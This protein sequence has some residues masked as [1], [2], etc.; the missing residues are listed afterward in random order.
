[1]HDPPQRWRGTSAPSL[2]G[3]KTTVSRGRFFAKSWNSTRRR[4]RRTSRSANSTAVGRGSSATSTAW[5]ASWPGSGSARR[6]PIS[7]AAK[8]VAALRRVER[9]AE[10]EELTK[11]E[12]QPPSGVSYH[13]RVL[14]KGAG[15][16]RALLPA[17]RPRQK[18][19]VG[20]GD[21]WPGGLS[22]GKEKGTQA[23]LASTG[24]S[25]WSRV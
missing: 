1:M 3:R 17:D 23:C 14:A 10:P 25:G 11:L 13:V 12:E 6:P 5:S 19:A 21:P 7:P 8:P 16:D 15:V 22:D 20:L 9:D 4:S 24:S 18:D 2:T